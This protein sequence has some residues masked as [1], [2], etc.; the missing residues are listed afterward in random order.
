METWKEISG[1][2]GLLEISSEGRVRSNMRDGRILKQQVDKK[3]YHRVRV[4]VKREQKSFKVHREVAKAFIP[5]PNGLPQV[6]HIDGNKN[7]NCVENLEWVSN[8]ENADHAISAGLWGN[9]YKASQRANEKRKT[10]VVS[11]DAITGE[12]RY[13]G[14]VSEAERFFH[15]RHIS[16]VLNG[17]RAKAAGQFF[18]R[19]VIE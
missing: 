19:G 4:T 2:F 17:E 16:A 11:V 10:P 12:R 8:K 15:N 9:V 7:N 18:Y 5:N 6:N 1:T 3:G 14:S 13:F